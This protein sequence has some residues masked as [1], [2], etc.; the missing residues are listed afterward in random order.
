MQPHGVL[1]LD[2]SSWAVRRLVNEYDVEAGWLELVLRRVA[3]EFESLTLLVDR[4][5]EHVA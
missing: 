4:N 3:V 1:A 5:G 2:N